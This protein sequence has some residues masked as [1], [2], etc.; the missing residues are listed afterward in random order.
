MKPCGK[1]KH[2]LM[3]CSVSLA[4]CGVLNDPNGTST[5][6]NGHNNVILMQA[7]RRAIF[8]FDDGA[9]G[10]VCPEPSPDVKA[11]IDAALNSLIS[12]SAN[13]PSTVSAE[14]KAELDATRK[15]ITQALLTRSQGLQM[16]RDL[17]FQ[18]C[19]ANLRG[20]LP[21]PQ[22]LTFVTVTLPRLTSTLI[23]TELVTRG[24]SDGKP[25]PEE[26]VQAIMKYQLLTTATP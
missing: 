14:A 12:G 26:T 8:T 11:D 18:A 19:L 16:L 15:I 6:G 20:D 2:I 25:L 17:L 7:D 1:F 4:S 23:T 13:L 3:L 24:S 10:R 9:S 22:Y 21:G 5:I